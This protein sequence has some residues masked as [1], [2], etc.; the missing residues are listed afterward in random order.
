MRESEV[1]L[2]DGWLAGDLVEVLREHVADE[3]VDFI[4]GSPFHPILLR[5]LGLE[6]AAHDF[7][8]W[9]TQVS[10]ELARVLKRGR[11]ML[12]YTS[13]FPSAHPCLSPAC[14]SRLLKHQGN[15]DTLR[16]TDW[17]RF[18]PDHAAFDAWDGEWGL[19]AYRTIVFGEFTP[20]E[21]RLALV[22]F[23]RADSDARLREAKVPE[24]ESGDEN[25][26]TFALVRPFV[27]ACTQPGDLVLFP[28]ENEPDE[29]MREETRA[30]GRR[31]LSV[32]TRPVA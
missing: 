26:D 5:E 32:L 3:S 14:M 27:E 29:W 23:I 28:F 4:V 10:G 16:Q 6:A 11:E 1:Q 7:V 30:L 12:I 2:P 19:S 22:G 17:V 9:M 18:H 15:V 8:E 21:V 13:L 31:T 25:T 24:H 20:E